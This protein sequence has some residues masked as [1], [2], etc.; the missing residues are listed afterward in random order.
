MEELR[1][2]GAGG[3]DPDL[4]ARIYHH[5]NT[6]KC[7]RCRDLFCLA[8]VPA[9]PPAP[10]GARLRAVMERLKKK[11]G[12]VRKSPP[13]PLRIEAGQLW[14]VRP[15]PRDAAGEAPVMGP[16]LVLWPGDGKSPSPRIIRVMPLSF[17][18][19]FEMPGETVLLP[20]DN[21]LAYPVLVEVFNERPMSS[22]DLAE[23][24]GAVS[25][26][27]MAR[28]LA[29]RE[30]FLDGETGKPDTAYLRWKETE[31]ELTAHLS[32]AVNKVLWPETEETD[33]EIR[34]EPFRKAADG[35]GLELSEVFP[36]ILFQRG[37]ATLSIVQVRDRF[38][39]RFTPEAA[40]ALPP[41]PIH[42]DGRR[43]RMERKKAGVYEA[44][45]G[46]AD[47]M[48]GVMEITGR[49]GD[50]GFRFRVRF[51]AKEAD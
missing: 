25:R 28:V 29:A 10:S 47:R 30:R 11:E 27:D 24:R 21:P 1:A 15:C 49:V 33:V 17:D 14:T 5:L 4:R 12:P 2:Y 6:E 19:A 13:V 43:I 26:A 38:L 7:P 36:C 50:R 34:P 31:L 35:A 9:P 39:L 8:G 16:V 37:G 22:S 45:I 42:I 18:T 46:Y 20:E 3:L 23:Y 44:A 32:F 48:P 41:D 40:E 51:A